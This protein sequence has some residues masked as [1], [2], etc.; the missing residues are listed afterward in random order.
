[1]S[2]H[3][4]WSQIQHKKAKTDAQ[5]SKVFS[6]FAKLITDAARKAKGNKEDPSL[7]SA[8][9]KARSFNMPNENIERAIKKATEA[10][11][12]QMENIVY[13][14]YGPG[15]CAIMIEAL[16]DNKNKAVQEVKAVLAKH[17]F[18]LANP[19]SASWAFKKEG[20][21]WK[22]TTTIPLGD[23]D[24]LLLEK[25][26]EELEDCDEVQEVFTNAE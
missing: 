24:V 23:E 5:K 13:E 6:K 17:G 3:N 10:G 20:M 15:G 14:S 26:I 1:M 16:T 7:R 25:L 21:E 9:E 19:G 11:A 18:S 12:S 22:P 8:M 4:K 2:G